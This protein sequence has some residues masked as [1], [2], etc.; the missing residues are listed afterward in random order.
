M[1]I[2]TIIIYFTSHFQAWQFVETFTSPNVA[3]NRKRSLH[4]V[5]VVCVQVPGTLNYYKNT[6]KNWR[7]LV[8]ACYYGAVLP[9]CSYP[10]GSIAVTSPID[11]Q[12]QEEEEEYTQVC[13][14]SG[15][16]SHRAAFCALTPRLEGN[17][18]HMSA[19]TFSAWLKKLVVWVFPR[20]LVLCVCVETKPSRCVVMGK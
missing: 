10:K 6:R 18:T 9:F 13:H 1:I 19:R 15:S 4:E 16:A 7:L 12:K 20:A 17:E 14:R 8:N 3:W 11:T 5:H 2:I